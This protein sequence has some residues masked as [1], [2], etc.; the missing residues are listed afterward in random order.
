MLV[1]GDS[2][3]SDIKG[4]NNAGIDTLW[5]NPHRQENTKGVHVE[6]EADSLE[7]IGEM[8]GMER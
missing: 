3:T 7:R 2:L 4:G 1:I 5:F 6:Y 8:L